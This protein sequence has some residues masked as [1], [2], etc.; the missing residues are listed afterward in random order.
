MKKTTGGF[1]TL[2]DDKREVKKTKEQDATYVDSQAHKD[3]KES[4]NKLPEA[5]LADN[6][7]TPAF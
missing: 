7:S 1:F 2:K 4:L 3:A 5:K 6:A